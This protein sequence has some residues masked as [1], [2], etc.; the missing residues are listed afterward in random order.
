MDITGTA[1]NKWLSNTFSIS[2]TP[3]LIIGIQ[4]P[5]GQLHKLSVIGKASTAN[6]IIVAF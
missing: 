6:L 3:F 1:I 4:L 5:F 2:K